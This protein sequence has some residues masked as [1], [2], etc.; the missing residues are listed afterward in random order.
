MSE[1]NYFFQPFNFFS[2]PGRFFGNFQNLFHLKLMFYKFRHPGPITV[3][4]SRVFHR[5]VPYDL[6]NPLPRSQD[7]G[8][9][10]TAIPALAPLDIGP[11]CKVTLPTPTPSLSPSPN[12]GSSPLVTKVGDLFKLVRL[13]TPYCWHLVAAEAHTVSKWVV[14]ILLEWFLF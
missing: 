6:Y 8:P 1:E 13:R 3:F 11:D 10:C 7:M 12:P 2:G 14:R 5:V 9:H 4:N